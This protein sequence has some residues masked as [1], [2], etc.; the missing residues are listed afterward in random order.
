MEGFQ[1]TTRAP[2]PSYEPPV[3]P[4]GGPSAH[5]LSLI[6]QILRGREL[7][8]A[9]AGLPPLDSE[10]VL[11]LQRTAGNQLTSEALARWVD[12]LRA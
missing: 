9:A 8:A 7:A 2:G 3:D 11:D 10:Q 1:P 4:A 6:A 12:A 5:G